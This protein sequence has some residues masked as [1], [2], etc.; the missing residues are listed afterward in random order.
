MAL[1]SAINCL[2]PSAGDSRPKP[3]CSL[4]RRSSVADII[5]LMKRAPGLEAVLRS[6]PVPKL[7]AV[8]EHDLW[9]LDLHRAFATAIGA[10]LAV[11]PTGH[12]PCETSPHQLVRDLLALYSRS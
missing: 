4:T 2:A 11:Y 3:T 12:S 10:T 6:N 5:S 9:P 1:L 8:G 7:V